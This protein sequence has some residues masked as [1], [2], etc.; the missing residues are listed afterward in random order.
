VLRCSGR[1]VVAFDL[2]S[3]EMIH[4]LEARDGEA[5]ARVVNAHMDNTWS[6]CAGR[7]NR[8]QRNV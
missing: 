3:V 8:S 1:R 6:G 7:C 4:A 2:L 5:L